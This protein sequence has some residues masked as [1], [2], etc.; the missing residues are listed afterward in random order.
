MSAREHGGLLAENGRGLLIVDQ[1]ALDRWV[2]YTDDGK[3]VHVVVPAPEVIL[4]PAEL[5]EIRRRR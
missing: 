1:H 4:T 3:T 2:D 5:D